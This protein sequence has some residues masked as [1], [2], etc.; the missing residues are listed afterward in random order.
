MDTP[1]VQLRKT[2]FLAAKSKRLSQP[3][4]T[5]SFFSL[6]AGAVIRADGR[7]RRIKFGAYRIT[8]RAWLIS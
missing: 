3:A 6:L 4:H 7:S 1:L 5:L 8:I 2:N